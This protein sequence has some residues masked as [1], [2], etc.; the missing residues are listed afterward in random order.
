LVGW[1]IR[2][3]PLDATDSQNTGGKAYSQDCEWINFHKE[4]S[5]QYSRGFDVA[6]Q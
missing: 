2:D 5:I 1:N 6:A 3:A 4:I